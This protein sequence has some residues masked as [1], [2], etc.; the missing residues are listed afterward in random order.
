MVRGQL[1]WALT[2]GM[3]ERV[4]LL[5]DHGVDIVTPFEDGHHRAPQGQPGSAELLAWLGFDVNARGRSDVP[6]AEP[7]QTALHVA[8]GDGRVDLAR[9][10]LGLGADPALRD[11]RFGS[12]PLGWVRYFGQEELIAL[13]EPLTAPEDP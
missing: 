13:L 7:R 4:W 6:S 9:A 2:H 10:L 11:Q 5:A 3:A 1:R 8:A 12:T